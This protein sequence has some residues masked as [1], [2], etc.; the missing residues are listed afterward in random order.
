ME[1][2]HISHTD[3]KEDSRI[4]KQMASLSQSFSVH[5]AGIVLNESTKAAK[6]SELLDIVSFTLTSNS[7]TFLPK[8]IKHFFVFIEFFYKV[9]KLTCN[10]K[11]SVVHSHDFLVLP[12]ALFLKMVGRTQ[13]V[14]YDAHELESNRNGLSSF[15]G[16]FVYILEKFCFYFVDGFITV[17]DS[18][19]SWYT[20]RFNIK[21]STVI[22]NSPVVSNSSSLKGDYL[23]EKFDIS[24]DS[25]IF[26][27]VGMLGPGRGIERMLD[28]F[29][30]NEGVGTVVFLGYGPLENDISNIAKT[31]SNIFYHSPVPHDDVVNIVNSADFG[32][33]LIENISLSDY[34][35]LPNKLFEYLTAKIPVVSVDFPEIKSVLI[36]SNSG[37][38]VPE[39]F[40]DEQF[41]DICNSLN[42]YPFSFSNLD[43][44]FWNAQENKLIKFYN[45]LVR[46]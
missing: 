25:K 33:I 40:S 1:I 32:L 21:T 14:I 39:L 22:L 15:I 17:S 46:G 28:F 2:L 9:L 16:S 12:I 10:K 37:L 27:Y 3:I 4:L 7:F 23:R 35:S 42:N 36:E 8:I 38:V 24:S 44:Y 30:S 18:I 19:E 5:G 31:S 29:N 20:E 43:S 6:S 11:Y 45:A 41:I 26:I 13:Y 34:L